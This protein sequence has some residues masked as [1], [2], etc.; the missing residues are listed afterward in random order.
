MTILLYTDVHV[1]LPIVRGLRRRGV[2]V[3]T[4]QEDGAGTM[5]DPDLLDRVTSLGRVLFSQDED[6]P[7]EAAK[8]QQLS[9]PFTGLIYAHQQRLTIGQFIT[10]LELIAKTCDPSDLEN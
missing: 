9:Q 6:L 4:A 8:R 1:P 7:T 5:T 3:M 2:D 10:E